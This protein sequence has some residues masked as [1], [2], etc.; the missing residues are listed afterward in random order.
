MIWQCYT[1]TS[2]D[3]TGGGNST[4]KNS[5]LTVTCAGNWFA[6]RNEWPNRVIRRFLF[7]EVTN[8]LF[9]WVIYLNVFV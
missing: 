1:R 5:K 6:D 4:C 8:L 3:S 9:A 7:R 2:G